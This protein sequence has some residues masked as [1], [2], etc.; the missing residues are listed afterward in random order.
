MAVLALSCVEKSV[1]QT[2]TNGEDLQNI[3]NYTESLAK[4]I[5]SEKKENG[6]LGNAFST[7][8]AM[9]VSQ[10]LKRETEEESRRKALP[11]SFLT[12][13]LRY[14]PFCFPHHL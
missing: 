6:L 12:G 4:K 1:R 11:S 13:L 2:D 3:K 14:Y 7:G 8:Q 10:R 9:Q 5:L